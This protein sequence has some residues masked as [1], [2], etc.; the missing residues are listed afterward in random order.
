MLCHLKTYSTTK[1]IVTLVCP[2]PKH[3][4]SLF[5]EMFVV[6]S[7][8]FPSFLGGNA[9]ALPLCEEKKRRRKK[10]E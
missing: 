9:V 6:L 2:V 1:Y 5:P 8:F 3:K 10:A 7:L 4:I